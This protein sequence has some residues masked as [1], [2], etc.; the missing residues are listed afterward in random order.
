MKPSDAALLTIPA[1]AVITLLNLTLTRQL[2]ETGHAP[3]ALTQDDPED[4]IPAHILNIAERYDS[5]HYVSDME[6]QCLSEFIETH[7][8]EWNAYKTVTF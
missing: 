8:D 2:R 4:K 6:M 3:V 5:G 1:L 7:R